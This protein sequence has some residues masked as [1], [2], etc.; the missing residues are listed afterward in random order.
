MIAQETVDQRDSGEIEERWDA[1]GETEEHWDAVDQRDSG[2]TEERWDAEE[3]VHFAYDSVV[4]SSVCPGEWADRS[5]DIERLV[6]HYLP[7]I[8]CPTVFHA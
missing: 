7:R 3:T 8:L 5:N 2:E 6:I 1:V 4:H